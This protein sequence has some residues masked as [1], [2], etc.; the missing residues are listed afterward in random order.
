M[1]LNKFVRNDIPIAGAKII[2]GLIVFEF[3]KVGVLVGGKRKGEDE[4][5]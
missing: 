1:V 5:E 4:F 3:V 2:R